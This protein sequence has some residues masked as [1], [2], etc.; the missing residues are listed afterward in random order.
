MEAPLKTKS[1]LSVT[2]KKNSPDDRIIA[3]TPEGVR[4]GPKGRA[5]SVPGG[6]PLER[7]AGHP[8]PAGP[9]EVVEELLR[10]GTPW[11]AACCSR[12]FERPG[13]PERAG[14]STHQDYQVRRVSVSRTGWPF[15][16]AGRAGL[17]TV[18]IK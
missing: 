7:I 10:P 2:R 1:I 15:S 18:V 9:S 13:V 6:E 17:G 8:R 11:M 12:G 4:D 5:P 16:S 14:G 3:T